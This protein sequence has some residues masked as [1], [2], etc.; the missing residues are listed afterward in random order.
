MYDLF[1]NINP[2]PS[3]LKQKCCDRFR[4]AK[5]DRCNLQASS[6]I[7]RVYSDAEIGECV[8]NSRD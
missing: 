3:Q 2:S 5:S 4:P 6:Q 7:L 8:Y 1:D